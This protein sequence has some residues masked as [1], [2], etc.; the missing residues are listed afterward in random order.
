MNMEKRYIAVEGVIGVGKTSFARMLGEVMN[1]QLILDDSNANPF[2]EKFY[3]DPSRLAFQT[4][5]FFLLSRFQQQKEITQQNLFKS[6]VVSD[7]LVARDKIFA[8]VNL[9][10]KELKLYESIYSLLDEKLTKPDLVIYLQASVD[11]LIKRIRL[12]NRAYE[13]KIDEEYLEKLSMAFNHFFF[14]YNE[15]PLLVVNTDEID[16]VRNQRDRDQLFEK[17]KFHRAGKEYFRPL[18]FS[19]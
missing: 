11:T 6:C 3:E 9:S 14:H 7:Y 8:G 17:I 15:S 19:F 1:A 12:R 4:Q 10:E 16:F 18:S 13:V 2:L 5:V